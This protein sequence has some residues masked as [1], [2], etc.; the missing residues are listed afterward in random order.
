LGNNGA[1]PTLSRGRESGRR[2]VLLTATVVLLAGV[3]SGGAALWLTNRLANSYEDALR[4]ELEEVG[5]AYGFTTVAFFD[6]LGPDAAAVLGQLTSRASVSQHDIEGFDNDL[7]AFELWVPDPEAPR[8]YRLA[9]TQ[10][11]QYDGRPNDPDIVTALIDAANARGGPAAAVDEK[12]EHLNVSLPMELEPGVTSIIVASLSAR[13]EF[14]FIAAQESEAFRDAVVVSIAIFVLL[15]VVG[16]ALSLAVSR[17]LVSR[18]R[19]E[20]AVRQSEERFRT[21]ASLSPVGIFRMDL[22][23]NVTYA[24]EHACGIVGYTEEQVLGQGW[25]KV[26]HPDDRERINT[27]WLQSDPEFRIRAEYRAVRSDGVI[28]WVLAQRAP[29][30][31][32]H[33]EVAGFIGSI[34]DITERRQMEEVLREQSRRDPLTGALNHAAIVAELRGIV[35]NG[36]SARCA[37]VMADI[38]GMKAT[39]DTFGHQMGDLALVTVARAMAADGAVLGRYGGDEFVAI[40]PGADHAA[41]ERY[42]TM[43]S[44]TLSDAA[45]ADPQTGA[46]VQ[47]SASLGVAVY[48]EEADSVADLI[49]LSDTA[50]YSMRRQ[51]TLAGDGERMPLRGDDAAA[52]AIGELVPLLTAPGRMDDKLYR[53]AHRLCVSSG[54]DVVNIQL[55]AATAGGPADSYTVG[56]IPEQFITAWDAYVARAD[57][58]IPVRAQLEST[59]RPL[60]VETPQDYP[61]LTPELRE[62]LAAAGIRSGMVAPMV[63]EDHVVGSIAAGSKNA[64]AFGPREAQFLAAIAA[65]VIAIVRLSAATP[66]TRSRKKKR[67]A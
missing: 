14:A 18:E 63:W 4:R 25:A 21:L 42:R 50:M 2:L 23:G 39:N 9:A 64:N 13:A 28:A 38:D 32:E 66:E 12:S 22:A 52:R 62:I 34:T 56:C 30:R 3:L 15:S 61:Q 60:I 29:E 37:V 19:A 47:L 20:E 5:L 67:A 40:L 46:R 54:Y 8:G 33:G 48:P 6:A 44:R 35:A 41:A 16:V 24:N 10:T 65:Q 43:V 17:H 31:D 55:Y 53:L 51:R 36:T 27:E 58:S 59:K 45:L 11:V 1:Q 26:T 57:I 49:T 7:L